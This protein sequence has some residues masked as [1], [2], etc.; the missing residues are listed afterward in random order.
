MNRFMY[1]V[2]RFVPNV[3]S[4]EFINV[5]AIAGSEELADWDSRTVSKT[6]RA[7]SVDDAGILPKVMERVHE[8]QRQ[9]E[10]SDGEEDDRTLR[11]EWLWSLSRLHRNALQFSEPSP[12]IAATAS[13]ALDIVFRELVTDP[14]GRKQSVRTRTQVRSS[15]FRAYKSAG[16]APS[17]VQKFPVVSGQKYSAKFD[18][19]IANG[20]TVQLANAWSFATGST[21]DLLDEIKAWA[22]VVQHIRAGGGSIRTDGNSLYVSKDVDIGVAY[23]PP[24]TEEGLR[25]LE[26]ARAAIG[27]VNATLWEESNVIQIANMAASAIAHKVLS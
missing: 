14:A 21:D 15:L 26:E 12:V 3:A 27:E 4:G 9:V 13:D 10:R 22:W 20:G 2:A 25:A 19:A 17:L 23:Y 7:S 24:K 18:F 5:A 1:S 16:L 6:H 8:I 11:E